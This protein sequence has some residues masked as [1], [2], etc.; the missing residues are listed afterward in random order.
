M[1]QEATRRPLFDETSTEE[2]WVEGA[3]QYEDSKVLVT[4]SNANGERTV[5]ITPSEITPTK[6]KIFVQAPPE[7]IAT[8][9]QA[10]NTKIGNTF[11]YLGYA[12]SAIL[13]SF[14]ILSASGFV[15]ARIVLTGSMAPAINTGDVV[16]LAPTPR[17][18]PKVGDIVAYTA[19]RFSGEPVGIFTHRI[20]AGD[21]INGWVMKGDSN[22]SPDVQKPKPED[23]SGVVFFIIPWIG[24]LMTP[25]MLMIL[26]PVGVGIWLIF[27]TLRND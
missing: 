7:R 18:Q 26:I 4:I 23:V 22:P 16:L 21:P 2:I 17:A 27:D 5:L 1:T 8:P 20:I 3:S 6:P 9:A 10:R 11:K 24:T 15:K 13:I 14:S 25:K 12:L 19:R